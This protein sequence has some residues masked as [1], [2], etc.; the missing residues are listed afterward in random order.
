[1]PQMSTWG[2]FCYSLGCQVC[3]KK[4]RP[5]KS[6]LKFRLP[7][8]PLWLKLFFVDLENFPIVVYCV[9]QCGTVSVA[10]PTDELREASIDSALREI[11]AIKCYGMW[12]IYYNTLGSPAFLVH[13]M[14]I[15]EVLPVVWFSGGEQKVQQGTNLS[16]LYC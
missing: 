2:D 7:L 4:L 9:L 13:E 8:S 10:S 1:M 16:G 12:W 6:C 15:V 3:L 14:P 11:E 5:V